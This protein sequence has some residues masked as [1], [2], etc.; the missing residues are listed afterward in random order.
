M[1]AMLGIS[2]HNYLYLKLAKTLS[3]LL[4][5]MSCLQQNW[6]RGQNRF[7][8]EMR[9]GAGGGGGDVGAEG[10]DGPNNAHMNK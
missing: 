7:C 2:L 5:L 4:F 3:F 6:R 9:G 1:E 8:L 10:R